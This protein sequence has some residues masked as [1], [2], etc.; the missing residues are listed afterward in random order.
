MKKLTLIALAYIGCSAIAY[1]VVAFAL[2]DMNPAAWDKSARFFSSV[3]GIVTG[4]LVAS[5]VRT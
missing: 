5:E 4:F 2:W 3:V 1:A